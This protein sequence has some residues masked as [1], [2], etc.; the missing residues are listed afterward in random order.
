MYM[1]PYTNINPDF[2]EN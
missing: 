2:H 1:Y